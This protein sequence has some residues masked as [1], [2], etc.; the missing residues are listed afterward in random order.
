MLQVQHSSD[1]YI[2]LTLQD[3]MNK[4]NANVHTTI[5][6]YVHKNIHIHTVIHTHARTHARTHTHTH[7]HMHTHTHL[8]A[9]GNVLHKGCNALLD[10]CDAVRH[11]QPLLS[12]HTTSTQANLLLQKGPSPLQ[13]RDELVDTKKLQLPLG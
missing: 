8:H 1:I 5:C 4:Y 12:G 11:K 9:V 7:T 3:V 10:G 13:C 6:A 2:I